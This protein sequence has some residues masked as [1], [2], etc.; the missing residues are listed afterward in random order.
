MGWLT[1]SIHHTTYHTHTAGLGDQQQ[2]LPRQLRIPLPATAGAAPA[3]P[4][5][6]RRA[7]PLSHAPPAGGAACWAGPA[8][9]EWVGGGAH[10]GAIPVP[11]MYY[12]FI[13]I[14]GYWEGRLGRCPHRSPAACYRCM[15]LP[16]RTADPSTNHDAP[17]Q[18]QP[19]PSLAQHAY[20]RTARGLSERA[21]DGDG[22]R[23][24][25][26]LGG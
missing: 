18:K 17:N 1:E 22:R 16:P 25:P 24:N 5:L 20:A 11:G 13:Y 23:W 2:P 19:P 4:V 8:A 15:T 6:D 10:A 7:S 3:Q 12:L 26:I 9:L 14:C 21:V